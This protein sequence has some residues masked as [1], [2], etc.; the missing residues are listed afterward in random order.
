MPTPRNQ[1][2]RLQNPRPVRA[3][4]NARR[5]RS[6]AQEEAGRVMREQR[7]RPGVPLP[8]MVRRILETLAWASLPAY[9]SV[10]A[11]VQTV[12]TRRFDEEGIDLL[13]PRRG[14]TAEVTRSDPQLASPVED[15][16]A[17]APP[18]VAPPP[19]VPV[20]ETI[21]INIESDDDSLPDYSYINRSHINRPLIIEMGDLDF[22]ITTNSTVDEE[23][24]VCY[25]LTNRRTPCNHVLCMSCEQRLADDRCPLCRTDI[26]HRVRMPSLMNVTV[27]EVVDDLEDDWTPVAGRQLF[28]LFPVP[29]VPIHTTFEPTGREDFLTCLYC[30][31]EV[32]NN[33]FRMSRH[34][35]RCNVQ[36]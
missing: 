12:W 3:S 35:A 16:A 9:R 24:V 13:S 20:T 14:D 10:V 1:S 22:E 19:D 34:R 11:E 30:R 36:S 8:L 7:Q 15:P 33:I 32:R 2:S 27:P 4:R 21:V 17:P 29:P 26:P 6:L 31:A 28:S 25:S 18:V 23:C 5:A